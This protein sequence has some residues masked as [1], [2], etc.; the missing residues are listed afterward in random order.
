MSK[1]LSR[2]DLLAAALKMMDDA[3]REHV[4]AEEMLHR[5]EKLEC[6]LLHQ[7]ELTP[8]YEARCKTATQLRH[9]LQERRRYKDL[10]EET[11]DI[12]AFCH[13]TANKRTI[14]LLKELLGKIRKVENYHAKRHYNSRV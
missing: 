2:S 10:L 7:I 4:F 11:A 8:G 1:L 12:A 3:C 14:A 13:D 6:D 5:Q 9:C